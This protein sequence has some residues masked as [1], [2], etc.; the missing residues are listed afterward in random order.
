MAGG[1]FLP[2]VSDN[3]PGINRMSQPDITADY[4]V[5]PDDSITAENRSS[6]VN[7]NIISDVGMA[8][9]SLH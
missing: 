5:V 7:H 2:L 1:K 6:R 8:F 9:Y 3:L 4:A